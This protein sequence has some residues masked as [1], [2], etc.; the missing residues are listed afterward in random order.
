VG[1]VNALTATG[2]E[3]S[4]QY[5]RSM[6]LEVPLLTDVEWR[7]PP[8][9]THSQLLSRSPHRL[10][11]QLA[12]FARKRHWLLDEYVFARVERRR[13]LRRVVLIARQDEHDVDVT[14]LEHF[15]ILR[16]TVIRAKALR[17]GEATRTAR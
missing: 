17:V 4:S 10:L 3:S 14:V 9:E 12:L 13:S 2:S 5:M 15:L 1:N 7:E 11:E 6:N 16:A 8:V